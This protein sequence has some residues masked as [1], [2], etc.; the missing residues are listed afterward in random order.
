MVEILQIAE[1]ILAT[2]FCFLAAIICYV[3]AKRN[4]TYRARLFINLKM[5]AKISLRGL[6]IIVLWIPVAIYAYEHG[7]TRI[8]NGSAYVAVFLIV[9]LAVSPVIEAIRAVRRLRD[10][11]DDPPVLN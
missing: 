1:N 11:I 8:V 7:D 3:Y 2:T 6:V 4:A 5:I 10:G 9:V